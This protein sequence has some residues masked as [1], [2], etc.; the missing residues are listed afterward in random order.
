[1]F[2][3]TFVKWVW[4]RDNNARHQKE[5][6]NWNLR[7]ILVV[8]DDVQLL[9]WSSSC[10]IHFESH[11]IT[12]FWFYNAE[13]KHKSASIDPNHPFKYVLIPTIIKK[14]ISWWEKHWQFVISHS[15]RHRSLEISKVA[16][17][18]PK[19]KLVNEVKSSRMRPFISQAYNLNSC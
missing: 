9:A 1:M 11:R 8:L 15:K 3:T 13:N 18:M 4:Y 7:W 16:L 14:L 6:F 10:L 12:H 17:K 2:H 19:L 5:S